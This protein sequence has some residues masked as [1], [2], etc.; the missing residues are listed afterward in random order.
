[1]S[2]IILINKEPCCA[3]MKGIKIFEAPCKENNEI[4]LP[5]SEIA[6]NSESNNTQV[7]D[8]PEEKCSEGSC[9]TFTDIWGW[10]M[11]GQN[12]ILRIY[13]RYQK[14]TIWDKV[15]VYIKVL[16]YGGVEVQP[17][18]GTI[19][20]VDVWASLKP[21]CRSY[22]TKYD[23]NITFYNSSNTKVLYY[24]TRALHT[25][26]IRSKWSFTAGGVTYTSGF[27]QNTH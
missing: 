8:E 24:E 13:H 12:K 11:P 18:P 23:Q 9:G 20:L 10:D 25:I 5:D 26:T 27:Y 14:V 2:K 6:N 1:M 21:R 19:K 4:I 7:S 22:Q 17:W 3:K 16:S 15:S